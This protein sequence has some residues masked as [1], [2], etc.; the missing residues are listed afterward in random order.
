MNGQNGVNQ[1]GDGG[2]GGGGRE[3]NTFGDG[4]Q[5]SQPFPSTGLGNRGGDTPNAAIGAG[6]GGGGG[7]GSAGQ[8][9]GGGGNGFGGNGGSGVQNNM[10]GTNRF[11]AA[12]GGGGGSQS[13][14]LGLG[15]SGIGGNGANATNASTN[16][17]PNTGS[18]GGGGNDTDGAAGQAGDG[19]SGIVI[20]RYRLDQVTDFVFVND[21]DYDVNTNWLNDLFP[22]AGSNV[23]IAASPNLL[24]NQTVNNITVFSGVEVDVANGISLNIVDNLNHLGSFIGEG[25]VVI[26]GTSAQTLSGGGSFE[27]LRLNKSTSLDF[28]DPTDLFGVVYVDQGTLN[29]NGNLSLRCNFGTLEKTAQVGPVGGVIVGDVTV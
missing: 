15:G 4:L 14:P 27:N 5:P 23:T 2:S 16:G 22:T 10:D 6:G 9:G 18:G 12:G 3:N 29:T 1:A 25:E 17:A 26:N 19:G 8:D 7:A 13:N 21:G 11:Y 24:T 20:V 28:I